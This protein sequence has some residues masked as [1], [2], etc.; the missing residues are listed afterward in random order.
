MPK[1]LGGTILG[2]ATLE[3]DRLPC[4][5]VGY[6]WPGVA[7]FPVGKAVVVKLR[8]LL[9]ALTLAALLVLLL[10]VP[11]SRRDQSRERGHPDAFPLRWAG[12]TPSPSW[13]L[14]P[15]Q[16]RPPWPATRRS[17]R[18]TEYDG[19]LPGNI[20]FT[21]VIDAIPHDGMNPL[22]Q[23]IQIVFGPGVEP[24]QI[25]SD[26][27]IPQLVADGL[28]QPWPTTEMYICSVVGH[29]PA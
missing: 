18:S 13:S 26:A 29:K 28:D 23:E 11:G 25:Y 15:R 17:T 19:I 3:H 16:R 4:R 5:C 10:A 14:S 7:V 27:D 12:V 6:L 9:T 20:I 22:W 21:S 1:P 24:F 8:S 2:E